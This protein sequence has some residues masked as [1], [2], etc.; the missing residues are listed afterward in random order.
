MYALLTIHPMINYTV[1]PML[2]P[3]AEFV[4]IEY[5]LTLAQ[6]ATLLAAFFP[7]FIPTQLVASW[8]IQR[9]G[10]K[11][12]SSIQNAGT[13]LVLLACPWAMRAGGHVG[14]ACCFTAVGVFQ[15]PLFPAIS[16]LKRTW[17]A[18]VEPARRALLLRIMSGGGHASGFIAALAVP[19]IAARYG[20]QRVPIVFG[21]AFGVL[22]VVWQL[23]AADAPPAVAAADAP[24]AKSSGSGSG[25]SWRVF[26]V[27]SV[28]VCL[29]NHFASNNMGCKHTR[30]THHNLI[31]MNVSER[32]HAGIEESSFSIEESSF[33]IEEPSFSTAQTRSCSGRRRSTSN[34][35]AWQL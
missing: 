15:S 25:F 2:A 11:V 4:A 31:S 34:S 19:W 9:Y 22:A 33:S 20:W 35:M 28:Q 5:G 32:L 3:L 10:A 8:L 1:R 17:T 26:S 23:F 30:N 24:P 18:D 12:I 21:S 13:C 7:V 6:K 29:F 14:L 27:R 16:V